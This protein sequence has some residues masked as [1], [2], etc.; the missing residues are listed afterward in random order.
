MFR[1]RF[2]KKLNALEKADVAS[3]K[4]RDSKPLTAPRYLW[5]QLRTGWAISAAFMSDIVSLQHFR[6]GGVEL[7]AP[8]HFIKSL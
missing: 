7:F 4:S 3:A 5:R 6:N 2:T 8:A 1:E